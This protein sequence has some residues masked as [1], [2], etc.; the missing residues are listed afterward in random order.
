MTNPQCT[1]LAPLP[2]WRGPLNLA[3]TTTNVALPSTSLFDVTAAFPRCASCRGSD[4]SPRLSSCSESELELGSCI[5]YWACNISMTSWNANRHTTLSSKPLVQQLPTLPQN[6]V[7]AVRLL[8]FIDSPRISHEG[9]ADFTIPKLT[10]GNH[11]TAPISGSKCQCNTVLYSVI[12][13]CAGCQKGT[14]LT[15]ARISFACGHYN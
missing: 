2:P 1:L 12:S 13:A 11:Y 9:C 3:R 5:V 4:P 14:W 8:F 7:M 6:V 15:C 10:A